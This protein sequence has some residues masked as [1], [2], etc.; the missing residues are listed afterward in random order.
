MKKKK[1]TMR[2]IIFRKISQCLALAIFLTAFLCTLFLYFGYEKNAKGNLKEVTTYIEAAVENYGLEYLESLQMKEGTRITV[3]DAQGTPIYDSQVDI[4]TMDNHKDREEVRKALEYGEG[5]AMRN[6]DTLSVKN[7]YYAVLLR[8]GNVLRLATQMETLYASIVKM[9][10]TTLTIAVLVFIFADIISYIIVYK[11]VH[12]INNIDLENPETND[13]YAEIKPLLKRIKKQNEFIRDQTITESESRERMRREFSA[14]VSHEL[15]TPLTSI[16]GYAELMK[17]G[18]VKP[19]DMSRFSK[20]I[21]SE[22][23]RMITLVEDIIKVSRL[24]E[25]KEE[26]FDLEDVD[27]LEITKETIERLEQTARKRNV[28]ITWEGKSLIV[29]G[30]KYILGE[31]IYNVT[32]NAIKYNKENGLVHIKLYKRDDKSIVEIAD[33]GIGIGQSDK[34]RVFER[35]YRVDKSHSRAIGGTGLG[36]SIVKHGAI[37]HNATIEMDS[38]LNIGT[39]IRMIF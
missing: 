2:K 28:S 37:F 20:I 13:I 14:N 25:Q 39:T 15:K 4:S 31:M 29:T 9:I 11:V 17:A 12:P 27:L 1:L 24:D 33:T 16:S 10:V 7:Y 26:K 38:E 19:E 30:E 3:I 6:S 22:A 23:N 34:E 32:E 18:V 35:F 21:Y 36:L 8:N 5:T